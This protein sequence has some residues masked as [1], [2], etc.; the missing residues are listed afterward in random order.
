MI[1]S[2]L[3]GILAVMALLLGNIDVARSQESGVPMI[4]VFDNRA[5][6]ESFRGM[7]QADERERLNPEAWNYLDRGV[8]GAVQMLEKALRFRADH[9]YS[10][11]LR[12][13]AAR[14]TPH[15]IAVLEK[16]SLVAYIEPDGEITTQA[17]ELPWGIDRIEADQSSTKAGDGQGAISN[18]NVYIIDTGIDTEQEDLNVIAHVRLLPFPNFNNKDC[19]GHGTHVAGTAAAIDNTLDVV[20]VAPAAPLVGIKVLNCLGVTFSSSV[21]K[22]VDLV[23]ANGPKPGVVN[24]SL[25]G[26]TPNQALDDAVTNSVNAGFF[27]AVAAGNSSTD[28]CNASPSRLGPLDGVMSVAATDINEQEASFSNFGSC[29]DIWAPGVDVLS[30]ALGGGTQVLSGTSMASPHVAGAAALYLSSHPTDTPAQVESAIKAAAV[31]TNTQSKD[32]RGIIRLSVG[33]F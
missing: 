29:V 20:G 23:T 11:A 22:G 10:A 28:A 9:V 12:G 3:L 31:S 25:G 1:H 33:G 2:V 4:V 19:N 21:I 32:G 18:V 14:L 27:Y 7:Y 15:Q 30:T 8:A 5:S 24:M 17:Q 16:H 13:F 6:F 26:T